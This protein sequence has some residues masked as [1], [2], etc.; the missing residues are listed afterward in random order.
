[1]GKLHCGRGNIAR[2][3]TGTVYVISDVEGRN[4]VLALADRAGNQT[5]GLRSSKYNN[6]TTCDDAAES[7]Q[8]DITLPV[9]TKHVVPSPINPDVT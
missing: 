4:V 9:Y 8:Y 2:G 1:L 3:E 5:G 6:F 7:Q